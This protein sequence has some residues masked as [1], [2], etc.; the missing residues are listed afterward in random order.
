VETI[1]GDLLDES[2][3]SS[4]PDVPNVIAMAGAKFGTSQDPSLTWATNVYLPSLVCQKY[5]NSRIVAFSTGNVYALV[6]TDSGGSREGDRLEPVGE[7]PITAVGRERMYHYHS[8]RW[9]IPLSMIR[10]NY[11]VEMRY[12]VLVDLAQQVVRGDAVDLSMG[13]FNVIWQADANAM[14]LASLADAESPPFVLNVT[15]PEKLRVREICQRLADCLGKEVRLHGVES[16]TAYLNCAAKAIAKYGPVRVPAER[17]IHWVA[18]WV[19]R[20]QPTSGK[21]THF[22]VRNGRF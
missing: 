21:P 17:L 19:A 18:D 13:Y 4:L 5:R 15:G 16:A 22:Q 7:Y 9:R 3:Y 14:A 6:S 2:F 11:A 10:L 8:V 1:P 20:G 12:G